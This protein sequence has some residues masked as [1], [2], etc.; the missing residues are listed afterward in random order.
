MVPADDPL[1]GPVSEDELSL[2]VLLTDEDLTRRA[3]AGAAARRIVVGL[4]SFAFPLP[5]SVSFSLATGFTSLPFVGG[6]VSA[7]FSGTE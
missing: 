6:F 3:C 7:A 5:F 4:V 2:S 1:T